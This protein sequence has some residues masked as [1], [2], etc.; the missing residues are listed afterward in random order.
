MR[1]NQ[2]I[3]LSLVAAISWCCATNDAEAKKWTITQRH[4]AL[5]KEIA[6][7]EKSGELTLKEA[8]GLRSECDKITARIDKMKSKN[9]GK[10]SYTDE[11]RLEKD[12]NKLS[13]RIQAKELAKRVK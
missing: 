7:G 11:N 12:L 5:S 4:E 10:L 8:E 9:G 13:Q 6:K 1:F 3:A 2:A